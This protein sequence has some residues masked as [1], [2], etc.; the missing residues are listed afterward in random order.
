M[1]KIALY[2]SFAVCAFVNGM[3]MLDLRHVVK[4]ITGLLDLLSFYVI[5]NLVKCS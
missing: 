5:L 4:N 3:Y 2:G 1:T